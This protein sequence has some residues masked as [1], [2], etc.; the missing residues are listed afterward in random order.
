MVSMAIMVASFRD[1]VDAW[2]EELLPADLYFRAASVGDS[3]L[4]SAADQARIAA[5][6]GVRARRLPAR[7]S[8]SAWRAGQ[9]RVALLARTLD[10]AAPQKSLPFVAGP[11][12]VP[13][14]RRRRCG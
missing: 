7:G 3:A 13:P 10:P 11:R 4:L 9:P 12:A 14:A 2:L 8:R 1:S 6:P 5:L